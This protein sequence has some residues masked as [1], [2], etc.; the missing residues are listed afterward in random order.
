MTD[1]SNLKDDIITH[2]N[3]PAFTVSTVM[4]YL[5]GDMEISHVFNPFVSLMEA[6]ALFASSAQET[7]LSNL[8]RIY[9]SL[10]STRQEHLMHLPPYVF[11]DG[12]N[13]FATPQ[14]VVFTMYVTLNDLILNAEQQNGYKRAI[15]TKGAVITAGDLSYIVGDTYEIHIF[16]DDVVRVFTTNRD[17]ESVV[18]ASNV[19]TSSDRVDYLTFNVATY[20]SR[21][22]TAR[23]D[24]SRS[25]VFR[26][27]IET[28]GSFSRAEAY[29]E[30]NGLQVAI[31]VSYSVD[32][33]DRY[34]PSVTVEV[35]DNSVDLSLSPIHTMDG[36]IN[37]LTIFLYYT[38]DKVVTDGVLNTDVASIRIL[39]KDDLTTLNAD[40]IAALNKCS[41][42]AM[43]STVLVDSRPELTNQELHERIT[44]QGVNIKDSLPLVTSQMHAFV[45]DNGY[46]GL[47][48]SEH[49]A[50]VQQSWVL[51]SELPLPIPSVQSGT[52]L[53]TPPEVGF[54]NVETTLD[55]L[56][57]IAG[58]RST[59]YSVTIP[60]EVMFT[61]DADGV[62]TLNSYGYTNS[63]SLKAPQAL[64][65][66][67]NETAIY[68]TPYYYN[69]YED[70]GFIITRIYDFKNPLLRSISTTSITL[71][72]SIAITSMA[73]NIENKE[74]HFELTLTT[75]E[76]EALP[77]IGADGLFAQ[78]TWEYNGERYWV[79]ADDLVIENNTMIS[80][81]KL[82]TEF[83]VTVD[84]L[85][86]ITNAYSQLNNAP[87][88]VPMPIDSKLSAVYGLTSTS[89]TIVDATLDQLIH[90][91]SYNDVRVGTTAEDIAINLG[92]ELEYLWRSV[93]Y[94]NII[95]EY[96][97]YPEDV[98][99]RYAYPTIEVTSSNPAPFTI[100]D[101]CDVV[102]NEPSKAGDMVRDAN[103]AVIYEHKK[104]DII[105][106]D[107]G[108]PILADVRKRLFNMDVFAMHA[109]CYFVRGEQKK[110]IDRIVSDVVIKSTVAMKPIISRLLEHTTSW[111]YPRNS[112]GEAI[113]RASSGVA[114]YVN[115]QQ[116]LSVGIYN[117][118]TV[119]AEVNDISSLLRRH[120]IK[121]IYNE[122]GNTE[123][124]VTQL[125]AAIMDTLS[126]LNG[127]DVT[128]LGESGN[129]KQIS[130]VSAKDRFNIR[131]KVIPSITGYIT[132]LDDI[133]ITNESF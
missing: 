45:R 39:N 2:I 107:S 87:T 130:I 42:F 38:D 91:V 104:G 29:V 41:Y 56:K 73:A 93:T 44:D 16:E 117:T 54:V 66:I 110:Y 26:K 112:I 125:S 47:M 63:L 59:D 123:L 103:G 55:D 84:G 111:H 83:E 20:N 101:A 120:I 76:N 24:V 79:L 113:S 67:L 131:K 94:K 52:E 115:L 118:S 106:D 8:A 22:Y 46:V 99:L 72:S 61:R 9:P 60:P 96:E 114:N 17:D 49:S 43:P 133:T 10:A 89:G 88:A 48:G 21:V 12:N 90:R 11:N 31:P 68:Y 78:V 32:R 30:S 105:F 127:V 64:A 121:A 77:T 34:N 3:N 35:N 85:L 5:V 128:G 23:Y 82:F 36:L 50:N 109:M 57:D 27:T 18:T 71:N 97:T 1:L 116:Q 70:Q 124:N 7:H 74:T 92:T 53:L 132:I 51:S 122:M 19:I 4:Q 33:F 62:Y 37:N 81:F 14:L 100:G 80:K 126:V 40:G 28:E 102:F 98:P 25:N 15:L 119:G 75:N 129:V 69:I 58:V 95:T 13:I 6:S 86:V 65:E 108:K